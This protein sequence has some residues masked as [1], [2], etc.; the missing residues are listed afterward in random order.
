[1]ENTI[2]YWKGRAKKKYERFDEYSEM[3]SQKE[4]H[5]L[6]ILHDLIGEA[7]SL[8]QAGLSICGTLSVSSPDEFTD[9]HYL[10]L[11]E[12]MLISFQELENVYDERIVETIKAGNVYNQKIP[13]NRVD[14]FIPLK[15]KPEIRGQIRYPK[16][17]AC[18]IGSLNVNLPEEGLDKGLF[19]FERIA[20]RAGYR[21]HQGH[22]LRNQKRMNKLVLDA[23]ERISHDGRNMTV[24]MIAYLKRALNRVPKEMTEIRKIV[25][26]GMQKGEELEDF[27]TF[28]A[29]TL[30]QVENEF[31]TKDSVNLCEILEKVLKFYGSDIEH[32][33]ITVRKSVVKEALTFGNEM[34]LRSVFANLIDNAIK[35]GDRKEIKISVEDRGKKYRISV[36]NSGSGI[37]EDNRD[38][39]FGDY[40][41]DESSE[42]L[43][44][45]LG[46]VENIVKMH[47]GKIEVDSDGRTYAQFNVLLDKL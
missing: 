36:R 27:L 8:K 43:G 47:H 40:V 34:Q 22:M 11:N 17:D 28:E 24:S 37:P 12:D 39:I 29:Y 16:N 13:E 41:K 30:S 19:Y 44:L 20:G 46:N 21:L 14:V 26:S 15:G 23:Q 3:F 7:V 5:T 32:Y 31:M 10:G 25:E 18:V 1:M 42:G 4:Q 9:L 45:G 35:H 38:A 2:G 6:G 33:G